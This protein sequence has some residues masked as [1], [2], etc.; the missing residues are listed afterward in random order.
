MISAPKS[1]IIV[2]FSG[3]GREVFWL[4][5]RLMIDV[6]G[7][8]DDNPDLAGTSFRNVPILGTVEKWTQYQDCEFVIAIGNP[9]V[10]RRVR[11]KMLTMGNPVFGTL[12]DPQAIVGRE[13]VRVG[14]GSIICAGAVCTIDISI[15]EH[16]IV[17]LNA[18]IGHDSALEDFCTVAPLAALSGH[19]HLEQLV[20]IG[21]GASVRQGLRMARGSM[22]GMGGV[23][24][25]SAPA[26]TILVGNPAKPLR[27]IES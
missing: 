4:A 12:V 11:D 17:N 3:F 22:L 16:C 14:A 8:V 6:A 19:T 13:D 9:R 7:F 15:G 5:R 26:D 23:L 2:G 25:Q 20:E 24:T 21:T 10:R 1:L 18:T 27:K